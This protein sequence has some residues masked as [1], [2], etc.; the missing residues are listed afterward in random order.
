M[1]L[2]IKGLQATFNMLTFSIMTLCHYA[3]CFAWCSDLF[4]AALNVIM[5][6][7]AMLSVVASKKV[8]IHSDLKM[9]VQGLN[10]CILFPS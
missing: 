8:L 2:S 4:I 3:E 9:I 5:L 1:T 10:T 7:V 6:N